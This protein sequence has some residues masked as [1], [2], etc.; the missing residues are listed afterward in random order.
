MSKQTPETI[1]NGD[2]SQRAH[3]KTPEMRWKPSPSGTV[4]R[5]RVHLVGSAESGQVTSLVRFEPGAS[6]PSHPHPGG[7][8]LL[9]LEG[10]FSDE[11]GDWG[12]GSFL[13]NPEGYE[14]SPHSAEGCVLFVKLRQ[15]GGDRPHVALNTNNLKWHKSNIDG[16]EKKLLYKDDIFDEEMRLEKWVAGVTVGPVK[17][18]RGAEVYVLEGSYEDENDVYEEGS[19]VRY[20]CGEGSTPRSRD[21][22]LLYIKIGGVAQLDSAER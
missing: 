18:I 3:V 6:F 17:N 11:A 22:C 16:I 2:M 12:A 13:L 9:I 10:V 8:E 15:Y 7:E 20:P 19:W 5:K 1:V 14:H 21:G 4:W